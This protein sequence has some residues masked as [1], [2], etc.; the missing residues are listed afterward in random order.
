MNQ[1]AKLPIDKKWSFLKNN[2]LNGPYTD[3]ELKSAFID[4]KIESQDLILNSEDQKWYS[5]DE[6]PFLVTSTTKKTTQL[7]SPNQIVLDD[8]DQKN[9]SFLDDAN[10]KSFS[11]KENSVEFRMSDEEV[12][13]HN[14]LLKSQPQIVVP[15]SSEMK[16]KPSIAFSGINIDPS[17]AELNS[18]FDQI[19][20]QSLHSKSVNF[21]Q[22][23]LSKKNIIYVSAAILMLALI[24]LLNFKKNNMQSLTENPIIQDDHAN[25]FNLDSEIKKI[26]EPAPENITSNEKSKLEKPVDK[27][28]KDA[29]LVESK[30]DDLALSLE[31]KAKYVVYLDRHKKMT[32]DLKSQ[33]ETLNLRFNNNIKQ[34]IKVSKYWDKYYNQW[35]ETSSRVQAEIDL[36]VA[37]SQDDSDLA[38]ILTKF[39]SLYSLVKNYAEMLNG[40]IHQFFSSQKIND[41]NMAQLIAIKEKINSQINEIEIKTKEIEKKISD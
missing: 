34:K 39:T 32:E 27:E 38:L 22:F 15:P 5:I 12:R 18:K 17:S 9:K 2:Y 30:P 31:K 8:H 35:I 21:S 33:V 13:R 29:L 26:K 10:L 11:V 37:Q 19:T 7:H 4:K 3:Q 6:I 1:D 36:S 25:Q 23:V 40:Q 24:L 14:E 16:T 28:T 20:N 41:E